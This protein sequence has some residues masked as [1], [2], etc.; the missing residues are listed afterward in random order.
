MSETTKRTLG[1]DMIDLSVPWAKRIDRTHLVARPVDQQVLRASTLAA[2]GGVGDFT[3]TRSGN[4]GTA[5]EAETSREF[6]SGRRRPFLTVAFVALNVASLVMLVASLGMLFGFL[7]WAVSV[8]GGCLFAEFWI[9][10]PRAA[11]RCASG[12]EGV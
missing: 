11:R 10:R 8:L 12:G 7:T 4:V 1:A 3:P 6:G 9:V 2:E 5:S